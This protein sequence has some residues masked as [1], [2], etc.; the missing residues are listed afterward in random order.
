MILEKL[1]I[2][3]R[4]NPSSIIYI[5]T[6][7]KILLNKILLELGTKTKYDVISNSSG[8][9]FFKEIVYNPLPRNTIPIVVVDYDLKSHDHQEAKDGIEVMKEIR[10]YR[11]NWEIVILAKPEHRKIKNKAMKTGA[12][13]FVLKNE[14]V[15]V[16]LTNYINA[17]LNKQRMIEER[18]LTKI[19]I[20]IFIIIFTLFS[21][22]FLYSFYIQFVN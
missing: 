9:G 16:R 11:P 1:K 13:A 8:E 21:I 10:E 18:K 12:S 14:N 22:A 20:A 6:K 7:D 19:A 15:L 5:I 2:F 17:L 4:L 3:S